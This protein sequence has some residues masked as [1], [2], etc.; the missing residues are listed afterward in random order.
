MTKEGH[1]AN[2]VRSL[3]ALY[4]IPSPFHK[5]KT[6]SFFRP[7]TSGGVAPAPALQKGSGKG[8]GPASAAVETTAA[9][10]AAAAALEIGR[11]VSSCWPSCCCCCV[12]GAYVS[13][14]CVRRAG[15]VDDG[16][17]LVRLRLLPPPLLLRFA[18]CG[19][20]PSTG[21]SSSPIPP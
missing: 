15:P 6:S 9:A 18:S 7:S 20:L 11:G 10:A 1:F 13:G 21:L 19:T 14:A 8:S 4:L 2:N 3:Y 16:R 12:C 17:V 5:A